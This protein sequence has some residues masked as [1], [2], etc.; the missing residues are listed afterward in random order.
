MI[1]ANLGEALNEA[2]Q[3]AKV[4]NHTYFTTEHLLFALLRTDEGKE[5]ILHTGGDLEELLEEVDSHLS[6]ME[7]RQDGQ[8]EPIQTLSFQR[9]LEKVIIHA[10]FAEKEEISIGDI[11]VSF[12]DE[13]ES[14]TTYFLEKQGI[15]KLDILNF[16]SHGISKLDTFHD[17]SL[18][19]PE[20]EDDGEDGASRE[21]N[22][23]KFLER[24]TINMTEQ[25]KQEQYDTLIG[26]EEE[27]QRTIE[28]LCRRRKNN[29]IHVG[30]PGVGKTAI[31]QGLAQRIADGKV[32]DRLKGYEVYALDMGSVLAG[33]KFRGDF[34]E[35]LKGIIRALEAKE[36][37]ILFIDEIHTIV[38]AGSVQGG[39]LDASNILKPILASGKLRC[40]G[41]TTHEEYKQHFEKD[42]ALSRRFQ[43]IDIPEPTIAEAVQI[44]EGLK[45]AYEDFHGVIYTKK[46]LQAA[47]E[48]SKKYISDRYLPDIA[49]DV[50]DEIGAS[51]SLY[52]K[53][54]KMISIQD[55]EKHISKMARVP[56]HSAGQKEKE[57]LEQLETSLNSH[58]FGQESAISKIVNSIKRHRAGLG[59]V[60]KPI[61]S[62]LFIGPT[63]VG[64][65]EL[66]RVLARELS[67]ELIR[68]DMSEYMEKHTI[69][70]LLGS[71]PGYVGFDQGALLTDS[72]RRKPHSVLLLDEIE[73]AHPDIY[74]ALL[75][76]MDHATITDNTGK[77]ADFRNVILIMTSNV[78]SREMSSWNIG[79]G[80]SGSLKGDPFQA[81]KSQFSPEFRNRL[82]D[83]VLF[84]SLNEQIVIKIVQKQLQEL[85]IQ[86][87]PKK[88][89][90]TLTQAAVA[91]LAQKGYSP[92]FGARPMS[93]LIQEEIKN[94]SV[95]AILFGTLQKGG[96]ITVDAKEEK[97]VLTFEG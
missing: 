59:H 33:T 43:K 16:I 6:S 4:R 51:V 17:D 65:T 60:E 37:A 68:F 83:I 25:A 76:I 90:I 91:Y 64:K 81:V 56:V 63:G 20:Q 88:I 28:I 18:S 19:E 77:A 21:Q 35:R 66:C 46:S 38:G 78:G 41:S 67:L 80:K 9:L 26:R 45:E 11:F 54:K 86:L 3:E 31:T 1:N 5:L 8:A 92:E 71:P 95:D 10:K 75:Q 96:R 94:P 79:F 72:I 57:Q 22:I 70:R 29:P 42:R 13:E 7:T 97:L 93:R 15:T 44:L 40:I 84:G 55:I 32:P 82:D 87:K 58:I 47:C 36:K 23:Q 34:E 50:M 48:L 24:F 30:D 53:Q 14:F 74:N 89:S 61:G 2:F 73:K 52:Q 49:I 39:S 27:L 62:Y 69:S 85:E 12:F